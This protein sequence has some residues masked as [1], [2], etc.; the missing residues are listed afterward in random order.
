MWTLGIVIFAKKRRNNGNIGF[1]N[2]APRG[3]T[4]GRIG[5][6]GEEKSQDKDSIRA[7]QNG[8]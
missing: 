2:P 7:N 8:I 3:G 5:K 1:E 6:K 4:T